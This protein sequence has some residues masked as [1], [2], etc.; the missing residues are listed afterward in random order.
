MSPTLRVVVCALGFWIMATLEQALAPKLSVFGCPP[1]FLMVMGASIALLSTPLGGAWA[2]FF[3]GLL[4]GALA[5]ANLTAYVISRILPAFGIAWMS[6]L[7]IRIAPTVAGLIVAATTLVS[8]LL[9]MF[10]APPPQILP[11]LG[12]TIGTAMYNG[13]L[14]IPVYSLLRR[15]FKG[16]EGAGLRL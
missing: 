16:K 4:Q 3:S 9:L 14:A 2:G 15:L 5:G 12:A 8:Q 7:D 13:V 10:L 1:D 11:F 6:D